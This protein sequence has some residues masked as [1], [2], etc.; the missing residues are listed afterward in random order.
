MA[1]RYSQSSETPSPPRPQGGFLERNLYTPVRE[2]VRAIKL[3]AM[4]SVGIV[5]AVFIA[6]LIAGPFAPA[7]QSSSSYSVSAPA[8]SSHSS[9]NRT[10]ISSYQRSDGTVVAPSTKVEKKPGFVA[11]LL[12]NGDD[13]V[14][15]KGYTREDGTK[16]KGYERSKPTSKK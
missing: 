1:K 10:Q 7:Q 6:I 3:F 11:R 16:V 8:P 15:V 13:K 5:A 4:I 14:K 2:F 9:A 12:G